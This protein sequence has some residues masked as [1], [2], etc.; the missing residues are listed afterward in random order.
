MKKRQ[1]H[2]GSYLYEPALKLINTCHSRACVLVLHD[3][4]DN[5][6]QFGRDAHLVDLCLRCEPMK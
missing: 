2:V 1:A 3:E 5:Y 6:C 4:N